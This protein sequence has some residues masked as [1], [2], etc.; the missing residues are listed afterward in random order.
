MEPAIAGTGIGGMPRGLP[1]IGCPGHIPGRRRI[2][3]ALTA[4]SAGPTKEPLSDHR[5]VGP[6]VLASGLKCLG[7]E[8]RVVPGLS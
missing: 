6:S 3:Y 8:L 1:S 7:V 5:T 2:R 4:V